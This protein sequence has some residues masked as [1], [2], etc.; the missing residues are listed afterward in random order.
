MIMSLF[1]FVTSL[2]V[3]A[4]PSI[5][6]NRYFESVAEITDN[7]TD[8]DSLQKF[9]SNAVLLNGA[10]LYYYTGNNTD[11]DIDRIFLTRLINGVWTKELDAGQPKV[12]ID[13]GIGGWDAQQVFNKTAINNNGVVWMY[14]I[15]QDTL[16][17]TKKWG[18]G[19]ATSNDGI[20][21][22]KQGEIYNEG[23]TAIVQF[24][25]CKVS[26]TDYRCIADASQSQS[27]KHRYLT[28]SDGINWTLQT[29]GGILTDFRW[30]TGLYY[31]SGIF[32]LVGFND[33]GPSGLGI[34]GSGVLM[35]TTTDFITFET[36]GNLVDK[37]EPSERGTGAAGFLANGSNLELYYVFYE[38]FTKFTNEPITNARRVIFENTLIPQLLTEEKIYPYS[39][40]RYYPLYHDDE[41]TT[42]T[43]LIDETTSIYA[44]PVWDASKFLTCTS[45]PSFTNSGIN[46]SDFFI[47]VWVEIKILGTLQVF[48]IGTDI[49]VSIVAGKLRVQ[50]NN[51]TKDYKSNSNI[52]KIPIGA[53]S[54]NYT[55]VGFIWTNSTLTLCAGK[56]SNFAHTKTIDSAMANIDNSLSNVVF[57]NGTTLK[58]R[59]CNL[60]GFIT[61]KDWVQIEL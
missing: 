9:G 45:G 38:Y 16:E 35:A 43:E 23:S 40:N 58:E 1:S 57:S 50:L 2:G 53:Y 59:S 19:Y 20:N 42:F 60:G 48:N 28:S 37:L 4:D 33:D 14:Y 39:I 44:S 55:P 54:A 56:D 30:I 51:G 13:V 41:G 29:S 10:I 5:Q 8:K 31:Y 61:E 12:I 36:V 22:T 32:Y 24:A 25:V 17:P 15:G 52:T 3:Q 49:I 18:V 11:G 47:K 21:F 26:D 6:L 46:Q 7:E 34:D 27:L